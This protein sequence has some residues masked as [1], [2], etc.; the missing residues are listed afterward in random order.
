MNNIKNAFNK[1]KNSYDANCHLQKRVGLNLIGLI[2]QNCN[3]ASRILDLGCGTGIVTEQLALK[4]PYQ[5]FFAIDIADRLLVIAKRRLHNL[6]IKTHETDFDHLPYKAKTFSLVFSNM[7]LH[8]STNLVSTLAN[9]HSLI[10]KDGIFACSI[11]LS[12]TFKELNHR[13]SLN[14][15]PDTQFMTDELRKSGYDIRLATHK[16]IILPF[17]NTLSALQSIKSIGANYVNKRTKQGLCGK[18]FLNHL[19]LQQL[20]YVIGYFIAR[21]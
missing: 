10:K 6:G 14:T 3:Q 13:I 20:T 5:D 7:A 17:K 11:P 18:S 8:W 1:A 9:I 4:V 15:F 16:K 19:H 12:G 21:K 2:K